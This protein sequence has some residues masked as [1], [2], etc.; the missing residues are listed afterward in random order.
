MRTCSYCGRESDE[1]VACPGC[2]SE[3]PPSVPPPLRHQ[4]FVRNGEVRRIVARLSRLRQA[5][6]LRDALLTAGVAAAIEDRSERGFL[7]FVNPVGRILVHVP[8]A[9][10]GTAETVFRNTLPSLQPPSPPSAPIA[11]ARPGPQPLPI[12]TPSPF[13]DSTATKCNACGHQNLPGTTA[14]AD[15][16]TPLLTPPPEEDLTDPSSNLVVVACCATVVDAN[17][18][19]SHLDRAGIEACV[20]EEYSIPIYWWFGPVNPAG[21]TVQVKA[22]DEARARQALQ[23][24][25][26][27][28]MLPPPPPA[29]P[30]APPAPD[31]KP[32]PPPNSIPPPPPTVKL[33]IGGE[34]QL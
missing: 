4:E 15:C 5:E 20:P 11:P 31:P 19:K 21:L 24:A 25:E 23:D 33:K 2:G 12:V 18:V 30:P 22:R 3:L 32:P 1:P 34:S 6:F 9:Q 14:C 17:I 29:P 7:G 26:S 16:G 13:A 8:E 28:E 27:F 10:A